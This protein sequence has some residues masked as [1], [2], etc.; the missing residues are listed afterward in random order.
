MISS[1][2]LM[3]FVKNPVYGQVKTR[4]AKETGPDKALAIY[5][6]LLSHTRDITKN[7]DVRKLIY[8][9]DQLPETDLWTNIDHKNAIQPKGDLGQRMAA[10]FKENLRYYGRVVIIG[11][12]NPDL[13]SH[14]LNEAFEKLKYHDTVIGP[15]SDGGYYLLGMRDYQPMLFQGISWSTEKVY[16][17]TVQQIQKANLTWYAL[18][19]NNDIDT[20]QDWLACSWQ[21]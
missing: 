5:W 10:A 15:A 14:T 2:L 1:A 18:Q 21:Q 13:T 7:L 19:E 8:Y 16:E 17:Q 9:S 11:S 3:V 12:D 6:Q 4:L 20:Y